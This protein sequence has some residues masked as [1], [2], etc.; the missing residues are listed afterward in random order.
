MFLMAQ[1]KQTLYDLSK[2]M[3]K[4]RAECIY[5]AKFPG[6]QEILVAAYDTNEDAELVFNMLQGTIEAGKREIIEFPTKEEM[7]EMRESIEAAKK[8]YREKFGREARSFTQIVMEL[9]EHK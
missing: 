5:I 1:N 2:K 3:L 8:L 9:F 7:P 4:L 6:R